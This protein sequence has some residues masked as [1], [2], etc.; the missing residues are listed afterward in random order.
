MA[1]QLDYYLG[2]CYAADHKMGGIFD[3]VMT[4]FCKLVTPGNDMHRQAVARMSELESVK[5]RCYISR[6]H[7]YYLQ[8]VV[9]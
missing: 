9:G 6:K 2:Q 5:D 3:E 1:S 4:S 7:L 8:K